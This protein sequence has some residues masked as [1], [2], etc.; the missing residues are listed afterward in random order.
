MRRHL[1]AYLVILVVAVL[2]AIFIVLPIGAVLVESFR[3]SGALS[4]TELRE[5]TVEALDLLDPQSRNESV[6]RW[7]E[8][9]KLKERATAQA[10]ALELIGIEV[11]WDRKETFKKQMAAAQETLSQLSAEETAA[12]EEQYPIAL[13]MSSKRIPL[14]FKVKAQLSSAE[15][16]LLR[17]GERKGFG[18]TNYTRVFTDLRLRRAAEN[19]VKISLTSTTLAVML[20]F[21]LAYSVNRRAIG[22]SGF[23][24]YAALIPLVSP[25]V[26]IATAAIVL[27]GRQGLVTKGLLDQTFGWIEAEHTNLYGI[28]GV[29]VAQVLG[30]MP[31]AFIILDNILGK[32]DGHAEE[33]AASQGANAFQVFRTVTLPLSEPGLARAF[34]LVFILC[35]TDFSNPL[36]IGRNT[37]VLAG[38]LYY[39]IIA[40]QNTQLA[41]ALAMWLIVP[42]L[43]VYMLIERHVGRR[44]YVTGGTYSGPPEL[45]VPLVARAG[46]S[47][48]IYPAIALIIAL[49]GTIVIGSFVRILGV[50]NTLTLANYMVAE[51]GGFQQPAYKEGLEWVLV[52]VQVTLVAAPIGALLALI[53]A[54]L[55]ERVRVPGSNLLA[56]VALL[57]AVLPGVILGIGYIVAFNQPLG[58][59]ELSLS[60]TRAILILNILFANIF[61][62]VLA[63]R[64]VLQRLDIATDEAAEILGASLRQKFFLVVLPMMRHA[65]LLGGFYV[66]VH[67]MTTLSAV[68]FLISP[69]NELVSVAIFSNAVASYYGVASAQSTII[70]LI[71]F[72]VMGGMWWSEHYGPAWT[73][74]G[75]KAAGRT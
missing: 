3:I 52:S 4:P 63:G 75:A 12:F 24:R 71:V 16:E 54:F 38:V 60:G 26:V 47:I 31:P 50:D 44:H 15:F 35:M 23:I 11:P 5:I 21:A 37:S 34:I 2:L 22:G 57:P 45:A 9:A 48:I 70:L 62:G 30:Y 53:I 41:A 1:P 14:A 66:F 72:S 55:V 51:P 10:L 18:W 46:L 65:A 74:F 13:V 69:G 7:V 6:L 43:C 56:F 19:S 28:G 58:F 20:A 29:I 36:V 42:A 67:G 17:T 59:K 33:A 39:E 73:R 68:V 32:A 40:F 64:A 27:F 8:K 61:V 49:Y 25:P